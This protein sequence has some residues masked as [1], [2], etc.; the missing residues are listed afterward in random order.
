MVNGLCTLKRNY[1]SGYYQD[2]DAV[3]GGLLSLD[4]IANNIGIFEDI[5]EP[6]SFLPDT[7]E[8]FTKHYQHL[9]AL[10]FAVEEINKD[11]SLLPN[12]SLGFHI[13]NVHFLGTITAES[14]MA[15][16]SG[17]AET[18]PNYSCEPEQRDKL[19]AVIG[20]MTSVVTTTGSWL[21]GL[22]KHP[23]ISYGPEDPNL[24][25]KTLFPSLYQISESSL[26]L[27]SGMVRLMKH[28]HW[29]WIGLLVSDDIRGETFAAVLMEEMAKNGICVAYVQ[30]RSINVGVIVV[31]FNEGSALTF[32]CV[33]GYVGLLTMASLLVALLARKLPD[34]FSEANSGRD[35]FRDHC[36]FPLLLLA[37][38]PRSV[39]SESCRPGFRKTAREGKASCCYDCVPCAKGEISNQTD[40]EQCIKCPKDEFPNPQRDQCVPKTV[41]FLS[42]KEPLGMILVSLALCFSLLTALVWGVFIRHRDTPVVKANHRGLSY[43]L[44]AALLLCFLSSLTF[45]GLPSLATCLLRQITFGITFSLAVSSV[46]AK[47]VTVVLAFRATGLGSGIRRWLGPRVPSSIVCVCS[48]VQVGICTVWLGTFPPF[49]DADMVSEAGAIVVQCNEGSAVAFYCVLGYMG[50]LALVSLTVAFLARNLPDSFNETKFITFSMLV[51]CSVWV[52][53]LPTYLS[54]RGKAMVA[55]EVFSILTS[56]AGLLGCIFGPKVYVILLRPDR[57]TKRRILG[58]QGNP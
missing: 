15:L 13:F 46:L 12:I 23:Q 53:F 41:V 43:T 9:L 38:T 20:G 28:F 51:F 48:L 47:T 35:E 3:I 30:R 25:D 40:V 57:N 18:V 55:V 5:T 34:S 6:P 44:L 56:S 29:V 11:L 27:P 21:L 24:R 10:V 50:L 49:P 2:G 1:S 17:K 52:S 14:T 32:Y 37:Q 4:M 54:T 33:L 39:C 16:L 42:Y 22:H 7:A 36:S 19:L 58:R 26:A 31:Q 8:Y 45:V